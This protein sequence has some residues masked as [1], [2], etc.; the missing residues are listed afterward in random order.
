M[1]LPRACWILWKLT[2]CQSLG[3]FGA[4]EIVCKWTVKPV[5]YK[6]WSFLLINFRDKKINPSFFTA[7][8]SCRP[9][10]CIWSPSF[11]RCE[12]FYF[13]DLLS[14]YP[15]PHPVCAWDRPGLLWPWTGHVIYKIEDNTV[16]VIILWFLVIGNIFSCK[17]T[18]TIVWTWQPLPPPPPKHRR[19]VSIPGNI[20]RSLSLKVINS[21]DIKV[22]YIYIW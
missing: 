8:S 18:A 10:V 20:A 16:T 2:H 14:V 15:P 11:R 1:D 13:Y 19:M 21:W 6:L 3:A 9:C 4:W 5:V 12:C 22:I 17:H 7:V